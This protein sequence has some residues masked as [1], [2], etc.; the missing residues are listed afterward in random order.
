MSRVA[1]S[2]THWVKSTDNHGFNQ[3]KESLLKC[4]EHTRQFPNSPNNLPVYQKTQQTSHPNIN[5]K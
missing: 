5:N 3:L 4:P 1:T 2:Q